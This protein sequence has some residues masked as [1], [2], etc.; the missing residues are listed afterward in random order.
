MR[1]IRIVLFT[2]L[3][4]VVI[5]F[6][7]ANESDAAVYL[8]NK[9]IYLEKGE[10]Y[11][12]YLYGT[13]KKCTWTS[14]N[15]KI[16]TV[17][18]K[19]KVKAKKVGKATIKASYKSKGK[20][21]TR[22]CKVIVEKPAVWED[23][24]DYYD[25]DYEYDYDSDYDDDNNYKKKD[26]IDTS[27]Y[28]MSQTEVTI[29]S[30]E[31]VSL[32]VENRN[33]KSTFVWTSDN[34]DVAEV[35]GGRV[36]G[37]SKG[38]AVITA[39]TDGWSGKCIVNVYERF[40]Y[41]GMSYSL[42]YHET[43]KIQVNIEPSELKMKSLDE[44]IATIDS[45][46]II[47]A[48]NLGETK[49]EI[50]YYG[51]TYYL[52]VNVTL[53][54][55]D[56]EYPSNL[57]VHTGEVGV[58]S[59]DVLNKAIEEDIDKFPAVIY[60]TDR[61]VCEVDADGIIYA[62]NVGQADVVLCILDNF[63]LRCTVK[64]YDFQLNGDIT[65]FEI[66][67]HEW[68]NNNT[69]ESYEYTVT[70]DSDAVQVT[71]GNSGYNIEAVSPGRAILTYECEG[72]T[73]TREVHVKAKVV[74]AIKNRNYIGFNEKETR[75]L[76]T[77]RNV[78]DSNVSPSMTTAQKV[79]AI[80][81]YIVLNCEYDTYEEIEYLMTHSFV[82]VFMN[83]KAVCSAYSQSFMICMQVLDIPCRMV[84]GDTI[85]GYHSWNQVYIDG[86][87]YYIDLTWD[88]TIRNT[89]ISYMYYLTTSL[90]SS[91][92]HIESVSDTYD[93]NRYMYDHY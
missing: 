34:P 41:N 58:F 65:S 68:G 3:L 32:Y 52:K 11:R 71:R 46:G 16:A 30:E 36:K 87:W 61:N 57:L 7:V 27:L 76:Q 18:K 38:T 24:H 60:S 42:A 77:I 22:K 85:N 93:F 70:S 56:F 74:D 79:K 81:D 72:F 37:K 23:L 15:K 51:E 29:D 5:P 67:D 59:I 1:K 40:M 31:S 9:K 21:K 84:I 62:K 33:S 88:D 90:W 20:K 19:G 78:I 14:S 75:V 44:N 43:K 82:S 25:N 64:V 83:R 92:Y 26:V 8:S 2:I 10:S 48:N 45:N 63:Y 91:H 69:I 6:F 54:Y 47:F 35:S 66:G 50:E 73:K 49:I 80:H 28:R 4:A 12:L 13:S 17:G 86:T 55:S 53:Q 89:E 39:T